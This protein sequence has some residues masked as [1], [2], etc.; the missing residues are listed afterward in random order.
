M[1][2][3]WWFMSPAWRCLTHQLDIWTCCQK[4]KMLHHFAA[5]FGPSHLTHTSWGS[6]RQHKH[7]YF[8]SCTQQLCLHLVPSPYAWYD[9]RLIRLSGS[10]SSSQQAFGRHGL[11]LS[12]HV[13]LPGLIAYF[14]C[15][16]LYI[17]ETI[18]ILWEVRYYF[19]TIVIH[20]DIT[21]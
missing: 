14:F 13:Q 21:K 10:A 9:F 18:T 7:N 20:K 5:M 11:I 12:G 8:R 1:C 15:Y 3:V 4:L 19:V 2:M 16:Y 17:L 6:Q